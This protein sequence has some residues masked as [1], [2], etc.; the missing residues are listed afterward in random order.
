MNS[1]SYF[2]DDNDNC[3]RNRNDRKPQSTTT[4]KCSTPSTVTIP[5]LADPGST[6]PTNSLSVRTPDNSTCCTRL[7]FTSNIV[8][9]VGFIGTLSFQIFKQCRNQLTPVPVG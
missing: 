2:Y 8:V 6:F 7:D 9:P 4:L 3:R 1:N 5:I